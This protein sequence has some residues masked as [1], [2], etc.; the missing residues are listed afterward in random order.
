MRKN[1]VNNSLVRR[2]KNKIKILKQEKK[3]KEKNHDLR[4]QESRNEILN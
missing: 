3:S 4:E 2:V 1:K